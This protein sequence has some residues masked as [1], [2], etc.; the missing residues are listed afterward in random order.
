MRKGLIVSAMVIIM[1]LVLPLSFIASASMESYGIINLSVYQNSAWKTLSIDQYT[2]NYQTGNL[3]VPKQG[4]GEYNGLKIRFDASGYVK[5][6]SGYYFTMNFKFYGYGQGTVLDVISQG[7]GTKVSVVTGN[8]EHIDLKGYWTV[9]G[10][11][12]TYTVVSKIGDGTA[13]SFGS[14]YFETDM[15]SLGYGMS[16]YDVNFNIEVT[17]KMTEEQRK[18]EELINEIKN[19]TDELTHGWGTEDNT[20]D[21]VNDKVQDSENAENEALGG[22]TDEEIQKEIDNAF[23]VQIDIS[24]DGNIAVAYAFDK[25]LTA[26]GSQYS[27][28][29]LLSLTLGTACFIIGRHT[30][31]KGGG[32]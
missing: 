29:L 19:Q 20:A 27:G 4:N 32:K 7:N 26:F 13:M 22:K 15:P 31:S 17:P 23:N 8:Q 9:D 2:M 11:N 1:A 12:Y 18:H 24:N 28:L 25:L 21:D 16:N 5:V 3:K 6:Q 14:I 30:S 10:A